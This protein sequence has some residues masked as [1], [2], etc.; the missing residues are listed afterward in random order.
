MNITVLLL[1]IW[2]IMQVITS[3]WGLVI[4]EDNCT[5][6]TLYNNVRMLLTTSA[7]V[8]VIL[9]ANIMC[10]S[11]CYKDDQDEVSLWI[12]IVS[13]ISGFIIIV[14]QVMVHSDI[15]DCCNNPET[16]KSVLMYTGV[17]PSLFPIIYGGYK[18]YVW[19][20]EK[21]DLKLKV[22]K[23]KTEE[24]DI[25]RYE[26]IKK[27][28]DINIAEKNIRNKEGELQNL[29]EQLKSAQRSGEDAKIS[30]LA[31]KVKGKIYDIKNEKQNLTRLQGGEIKQSIQKPKNEESVFGSLFGYN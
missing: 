5:N 12:P 27:Q 24:S 18:L 11:I 21:R 6:S 19:I 1:S 22:T 14:L 17:F 26:Q 16:F 7:V 31:N 29:Q 10:H 13:L 23:T 9:F 2:S 3:I 4:I 8:S 25:K 15:G 28:A 30:D 20:K